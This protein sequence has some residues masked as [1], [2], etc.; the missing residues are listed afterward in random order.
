M[1]RAPR[2]RAHAGVRVS[3]ID[4]E[5]AIAARALGIEAPGGGFRVISADP[6]WMFK[7]F[8]AKGEGRSASQ[9]YNT[10]SLDDICALPVSD[11]AARDCHLFLWVTGSNLPHGLRV[12]ESW[13]FRYSGTAFVWVK[14]RKDGQPAI[15][16]GHTT[17]KSA[18]FCLLGRRGAPKR[19]SKAVREV[20]MSP[21]R[22]HSRKPDETYGRIETYADG[23]YL[24][25]FARQPWPGW[26][27]WGNQTDRFA[28]V[29]PA[30]PPAVRPVGAG[31]DARLPLRGLGDG[32]APGSGAA[33][34]A[35][36]VP[37]PAPDEGRVS[38]PEADR[39]RLL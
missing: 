35:R 36:S 11:L 33:G 22:E 30:V 6:P 18:E 21:R 20:I 38:Q 25:L 19:K 17:R 2:R 31:G 9:H 23:P 8:S 29:S 26:T 13:G 27:A 16:M 12:M 14:T 28:P 32:C 24:E 37:Q 34:D 3:Q 5:E 39:S 15:G 4:L 10:M 7:V 1:G